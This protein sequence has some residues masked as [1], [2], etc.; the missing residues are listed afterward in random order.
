MPVSQAT[1]DVLT[2]PTS[3][4]A[5]RYGFSPTLHESAIQRL[6]DPRR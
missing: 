3:V 2:P 6:T 4:A 1:V 5:L